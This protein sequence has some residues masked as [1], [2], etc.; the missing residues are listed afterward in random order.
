MT[1]VI[2]YSD[3]EDTLLSVPAQIIEVKIKAKTKY[4]KGK[5]N[6][7]AFFDAKDDITYVYF[8]DNPQLESIPSFCFDQCTKLEIVELNKCKNLQSIGEKAF[9]NCSSLKQIDF[10]ESLKSIEASAFRYTG[11]TSVFLSKSLVSFGTYVFS[12]CYKLTS[13]TIDENTTITRLPDHIISSSKITNITLPKSMKA[14]DGSVFSGVT[15]LT[16]IFIAAGNTYLIVEDNVVFKTDKSVLYYCA[17]GKTGEYTVPNEV[18]TLASCSFISSSLSK[19]Y[20]PSNLTKIDSWAFLSSQITEVEIPASCLSI[21]EEAFITCTKLEKVTFNEGLEI[22]SP[23]C[24]KGCSQLSDVTLPSTLKKLGGSAFLNCNKNLTLQFAPGSNLSIDNQYLIT[25]K[26]NTTLFQCAST[27]ESIKIPSSIIV[28]DA[29][30]FSSITTIETITFEENS[31]LI[32]IN[33]NAFE[34]C[35]NLKTI[36]LPSSIQSIE[37]NAFLMCTSLGSVTFGSSLKTIREY[38]FSGCS[39]ITSVVFSDPSDVTISDYAFQNCKQLTTFD[40]KNSIRSLGKG[41]LYNCISLTSIH[42]PSITSSIGSNAFENCGLEECIFENGNSLTTL[43]AFTF[44][45]CSKLPSIELP[46]TIKSIGS[47]S[48]SKTS[49]KSIV[50]PASVEKLEESCFEDCKSL[51]E[52]HIPAGSL[53]SEIEIDVFNLCTSF[54]VIE[55]KCDNFTIENFALFNKDKTK[56]IVLP[57]NSSVKYFSFPE[58]LKVI[59]IG[60][61]QGW[62]N[63]QV[64][65]IPYSVEEIRANAFCNCVNLH[66]INIPY[67]VTTIG[68]NAFKGCKNLQCGVS[69]DNTTSEYKRNLINVAGLHRSSLLSCK[70]AFTC[71][72]K[73]PLLERSKF[74]VTLIF[75]S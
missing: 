2:R 35:T 56:L 16:N 8:E 28:I 73:K 18:T 69:M 62:K 48:L 70:A 23:K 57:P 29:S 27:S 47:H 59:S 30:S 33:K 67:T 54:S 22:I 4:I 74:Y 52:V 43:E 51:T 12:N 44:Y 55:N 11:L 34:S 66:S 41:A 20:L 15:T 14:L 31:K 65:F 58:T 17:A 75:Y 26:E 36:D 72:Q 53:L 6:Q 38:A 45:N 63:L 71:H 25:D 9:Y 10:P 60:A 49:I 32:S 68:T 64:I 5:E 40:C 19:V 37:K 7:N 3:N 24:F 39:N 46:G 21:G 61:L 13:F 42:I 1:D 50:I